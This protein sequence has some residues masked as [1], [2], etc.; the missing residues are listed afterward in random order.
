[1]WT[2][3]EVSFLLISLR[4]F[5]KLKK[6]LCLSR[7]KK[8]VKWRKVQQQTLLE[9]NTILHLLQLLYDSF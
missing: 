5:E 4:S 3:L 8:I 6:R 1:M 2:V 7:P 9:K